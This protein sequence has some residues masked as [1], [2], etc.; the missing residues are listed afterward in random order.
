M[1]E[2]LAS[3]AYG[4][5]GWGDE[6][7]SGLWLTVRLALT[8]LPFG[9]GIGLGVALLKDSRSWTGRLFG[10]AYTTVFR[11]LPELLTIFIVYFGAPR[12][13][14]AS[15]AW[16]ER[17]TGR[18]PSGFAAAIDGFTAGV[19]ALA[20]VF[21]AFSSEVLL[22][23]IRGVP[24]SQREAAEALGLSRF[25]TFRLVILPQVWRL[26]LPGL[27]NNWLVMLK[28]TSLVSVTALAELMRQ[29]DVAARATHEP[30]L[31]YLVACLLYLTLSGLST[32]GGLWLERRASRGLASAAR[33]G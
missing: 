28:D 10:E 5:D 16:A 6:L 23:A 12:L 7:L 31:F 22:G 33:Q 25:A 1:S 13:L 17:L 24:E 3:L 19:V 30:F 9:L 14:S 18:E 2:A 27:T 15:V 32:V 26:A 8:A 20:L 11:G 21:G 29:A 4:P